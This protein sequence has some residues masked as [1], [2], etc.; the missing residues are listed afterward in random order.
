M[1]SFVPYATSSALTFSLLFLM[2]SWESATEELN[3]KGSLDRPL[4]LVPLAFSKWPVN[5]EGTVN[6]DSYVYQRKCTLSWMTS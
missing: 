1:M 5:I 2:K 6:K 3:E 4:A